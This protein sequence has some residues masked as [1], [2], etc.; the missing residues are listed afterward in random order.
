MRVYTATEAA[1]VC[2]VAPTTVA[3]W[4]DRGRLKCYRIPGSR[5]RRIPKE[6]LLKFLREH[7]MP[8]DDVER[9]EDE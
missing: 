1:K 3:K 2:R 7:G 5:D 8:T 6:Y 4:C 9:E